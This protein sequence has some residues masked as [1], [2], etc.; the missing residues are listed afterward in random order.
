M[1]DVGVGD[2]C[3]FSAMVEGVVD[4]GVGFPLMTVTPESVI[5]KRAVQGRAGYVRDKVPG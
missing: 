5:S 2:C 1:D 3:C 4:C